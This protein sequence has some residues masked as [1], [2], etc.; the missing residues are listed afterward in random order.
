MRPINP[1]LPPTAPPTMAP[2]WEVVEGAGVLVGDGVLVGV[3]VVGVLDGTR[4]EVVVGV[5][6]GVTVSGDGVGVME[7]NAP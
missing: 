5:G 4:A 1:I 2:K 3:L 7:A 6:L